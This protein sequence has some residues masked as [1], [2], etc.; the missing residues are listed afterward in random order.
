MQEIQPIS[1]RLFVQA[2]KFQLK[3]YK[4]KTRTLFVLLLQVIRNLGEILKK[5]SKRNIITII[6]NY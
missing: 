5:K 1:T 6:N 2:H 4:A 3:K